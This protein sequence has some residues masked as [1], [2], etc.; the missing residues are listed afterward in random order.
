M[1][2]EQ[3]RPKTEQMAWTVANEQNYLNHVFENHG[4]KID[5]RSERI[6][7]IA[8]L[9]TWIKTYDKRRWNSP[10]MNTLLPFA[11]SLLKKLLDATPEKIAA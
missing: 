7:G 9:T 11:K 6:N 10:G 1:N 4:K 3:P 5:S 2:H 8:I